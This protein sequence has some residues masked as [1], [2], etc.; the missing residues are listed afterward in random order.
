MNRKKIISILAAACCGIILIGLQPAQWPTPMTRLPP[1]KK[2][3]L[4]FPSKPAKSQRQRCMVMFPATARLNPRPQRRTSPPRARNSLRP[5]AGVVTKVNVVEGQQV[6]KGDVLVELNSGTTTAENAS[7][8]WSGRKIIRAAKHVVE[9]FAGCRGA[10]GPVAS[11]RA[12]VRHGHARQRQAGPGGGFDDGRRGG[13]GFEPA[14]R[15]RGNSVG[16]GE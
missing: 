2:L 15:E 8:K 12:A 14:R 6:A 16:G 3:Q 10:T 11:H 7:R 13:D 4:W 1:M 9:K 5:S